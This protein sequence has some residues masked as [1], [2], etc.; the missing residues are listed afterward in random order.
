MNSIT[1]ELE[2]YLDKGAELAPAEDRLLGSRT[3]YLS[4]R[5]QIFQKSKSINDQLN[6]MELTINGIT[7]SVNEGDKVSSGESKEMAGVE[8]VFNTYYDTMKWIEGSTG[9]IKGKLQE[10][11]STYNLFKY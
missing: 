10:I 9:E 5:E 8:R 11:E 3:N 1:A 2:P 6:G 4:S 7:N